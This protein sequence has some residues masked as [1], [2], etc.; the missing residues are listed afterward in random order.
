M[1]VNPALSLKETVL[2]EIA[3]LAGTAVASHCAVLV[4]RWRVLGDPVPSRVW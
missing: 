3:S 2:A 4:R 1:N